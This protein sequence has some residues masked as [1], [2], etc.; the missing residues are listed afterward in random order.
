MWTILT[1]LLNLLQYC[2]V[3]WCF[4]QEAS[5]ILASHPEIEPGPSALESEGLTPGAPGK[6]QQLLKFTKTHWFILLKWVKFIINYT[7]I[8]LVILKV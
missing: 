2:S 5:E 8:K 7:S 4:G 3:F 1:S 6:T